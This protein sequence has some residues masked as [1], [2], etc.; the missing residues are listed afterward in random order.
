M[1]LE[2]L[3]KKSATED[4]D[5]TEP[6]KTK[7]I[8]EETSATNN[9]SGEVESEV[10]FRSGVE[11][12]SVSDNAIITEESIEFLEPVKPEYVSEEVL[13]SS[14]TEELDIL[15]N[16]PIMEN[17]VLSED[18]TNELLATIGE[19]SVALEDNLQMD[20]GDLDS[21]VSSLKSAKTH[22]KKSFAEKM[23]E[24][25]DI[26]LERYDIL[27]NYILS[28]KKIKSRISNTADTFNIGRTQYFK[29]SVSG[30]SLKLYL[31]LNVD[32]I[33]SKFNII[34]VSNTKSYEQV[35]AFLRIRSNRAMNYAYVLIDRVVNNF[36]LE[37]NPKA[38]RVDS[39]KLLKENLEK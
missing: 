31:N 28:F 35:P 22:V 3:Y 16:L 32:S 4:L 21:A 38:V 11:D 18:T 36:G 34:D 2:V 29:L 30:K 19:E 26:I 20:F 8:E 24:A 13:F 12:I 10:L 33:E 15:G 23:F 5:Y 39:I 1:E 14:E 37:K 17:S 27:K 25:E 6:D 9:K 7:A